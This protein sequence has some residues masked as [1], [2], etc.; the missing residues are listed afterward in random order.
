MTTVAQQLA[1]TAGRSREDIADARDQA[2][3]AAALV[4]A[5][6]EKVRDGQPV[7][8]ADL[9]NAREMAR[10][11]E[12][13]VEAAE[14]RAVQA[15]TDARRRAYEAYATTVAADRAAADQLEARIN[16]TFT[17][18]R[19]VLAE[20]WDLAG[21][22]ND[23][24]TRITRDRGEVLTV[25]QQHGEISLLPAPAAPR[26]ACP[27]AELAALPLDHLLTD[28]LAEHR[29]TGGHYASWAGEVDLHLSK[30]RAA[31]PNLA[32][33]TVEVRLSQLRQVART[34]ANEQ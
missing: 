12:L 24:F 23:L 5:L 21:Q 8:P 14:R 11:A 16:D 31:F 22:R 6:E 13:G 4:D 3:E 18:A 19:E 10:I 9:A 25:A 28:K 32:P 29:F 15:A 27:P 17:R 7:T 1:V 33:P 20:L 26:P 2:A 34:K 30:G